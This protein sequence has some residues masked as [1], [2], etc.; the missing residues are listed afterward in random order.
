MP[1]PGKVIAVVSEWVN[2][3]EDDLKTAAYLPVL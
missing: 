1:E 3:A 2:K